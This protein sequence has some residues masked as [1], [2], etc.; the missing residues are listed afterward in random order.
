MIRN[1][2]NCILPIQV[3]RN[4][5]GGGCVCVSKI[6]GIFLQGL[7]FNVISVTRGSHGGPISRGKNVT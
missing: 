1:S 4:A 5:D 3:L 6:P 7:R 2:H